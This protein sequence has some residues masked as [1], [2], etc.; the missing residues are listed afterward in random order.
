MAIPL[1]TLLRHY[2]RSDIQEAM[3]RAAEDKEIA[4]KY[5]DKGFGKRPDV[6]RNPR[7]V[8]EFA[9]NG[10]TSFDCS[11]ELWTNPLLIETGKRKEDLDQIRKGWDL[12]LDIDCKELRYS[13]IAADLLVQALRYHDIEN[14]TV[15]FSGNHGFHIAVPFQSFPEEVQGVATSTLFPE[16]PRRIAGYLKEMI[17]P[18]LAQRLLESDKDTKIIAKNAGVDLTKLIVNGQFDPFEALAIDTILLSSRHLYRMPFSFNEKSGL[19]SIP[20][21]PSKILEFDRATATAESVEGNKHSFLDTGKAKA[22]EARKL[23]IQAF[24][25]KL[26]EDKIEAATPKGIIERIGGGTRPGFEE[27]QFA[28]QEE[29]FPPCIKTILA[30]MGDG[31]KRAAFVLVNFLRSVGWQ[32]DKIEERLREWNKNNKPEMLRDQDMLAPLRYHSAKKKSMPPNCENKQYYV[33][34]AICK[35]DNLCR[36][37]KNPAQYSLRKARAIAENAPKKRGGRK[38]EDS[39][40]IDNKEHPVGTND[41]PSESRTDRSTEHQSL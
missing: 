4:V 3:V 17:K 41:T 40:N 9:K 26:P 27:P 20:I 22:G 37:I 35:P 24:D 33:D 21:D 14:I 7:D 39:Q 19:V 8:I 2:K 23:I 13:Q 11:E 1:G 16:G 6:L 10:S 28:L 12:I 5:G 18:H 32:P 30:G 38:K 34:V 25:Y 31:K 36:Y 15:K 29:L